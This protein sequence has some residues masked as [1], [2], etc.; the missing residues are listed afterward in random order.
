MR[1]YRLSARE[2]I[3]CFAGGALLTG[4]GGVVASLIAGSLLVVLVALLR[5][6]DWVKKSMVL[7]DAEEMHERFPETFDLPA[8]RAG[9]V[10]GDLAKLSFGG[11]ERMWVLVRKV[12]LTATY[13]VSYEGELASCPVIVCLKRGAR[14]AFEP[15]HVYEVDDGAD[16][17]DL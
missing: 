3:A 8:G 6:R 4:R 9:L 15:R 12:N 1:W 7:V 16:L 10:P 2:T 14:I 11:L 13:G 17:K 5:Y